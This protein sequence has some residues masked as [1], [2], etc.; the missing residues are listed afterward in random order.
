VSDLAIVLRSLR[1]RLFSTIV[2]VATVGIAVCLLLT[3]LSLQAAGAKAFLRGSGN[4][5]IL[6][7]AEAG[8]LVSVLNAIFYAGA[9]Q[10]AIPH[11]KFEEVRTSFPWSWAIPIQQ[12][13][14]YE[15]IPTLATTPE[16]FTKFEPVDGEPWRFAHGRVVFLPRGRHSRTDRLGARSRDLRAAAEFVDSPRAR[17]TGSGGARRACR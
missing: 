2:T 8:P 10:R 17:S 9:P 3:L 13:D 16:F 14:S 11:A 5:H 1:A 4:T 15:G 7:S 6:V 12:G